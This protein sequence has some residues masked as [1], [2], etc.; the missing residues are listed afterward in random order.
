MDRPMCDYCHN[1]ATIAVNDLEEIEP[2]Q[3]G[4]G[5]WSRWKLRGKTKY[6]CAN[7]FP[8]FSK[9]YMLDGTVWMMGHPLPLPDWR[10]E[11]KQGNS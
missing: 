4:Y 10:E 6:S 7:H 3:D 1:P 5:T 8:G 9:S 11:I 2:V